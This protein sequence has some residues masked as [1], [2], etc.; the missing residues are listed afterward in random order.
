MYI[1]NELFGLRLWAEIRPLLSKLLNN[2]N[3]SPDEITTIL[4][5]IES[6]TVLHQGTRF[7]AKDKLHTKY[8]KAFDRCTNLDS[9]IV[10]SVFCRG[11]GLHYTT[12][13]CRLDDSKYFN[14]HIVGGLTML[15]MQDNTFFEAWSDNDIVYAFSDRD[16]EICNCGKEY[17]CFIIEG[18]YY[19]IY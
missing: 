9:M 7:I 5:S 6:L 19:A 16:D 13:L 3:H 2:H 11:V 4:L 1:N 18:H 8:H 14:T 10:M 15:S 17:E 12:L